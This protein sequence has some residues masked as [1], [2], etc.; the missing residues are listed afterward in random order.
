MFRFLEHLSPE[1]IEAIA[2]FVQMEM[3]EAGY[4][5]NVEFHYLHHQPSGIPYANLAETANRIV[6]AAKQTGIGLTL[7]PVHYEF[8]GCDKRP[9]TQGQGSLWK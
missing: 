2:A 8:G 1:H 7:L 4:A 6:A 3:L 5:T 9:L